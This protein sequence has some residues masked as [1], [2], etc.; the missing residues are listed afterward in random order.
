[1]NTRIKSIFVVLLTLCLAFQTGVV[2]I[3]AENSPETMSV[4]TQFGVSDETESNLIAEYE[5][6]A[7]NRKYTLFYDKK[8]AWFALKENENGY[9][10]YSVPN[11]FLSD[12]ITKLQNKM[13]V[14]SQLIVDYIYNP[15]ESSTS[16]SK[17]VNSHV[18][19]LLN[20]RI[21]TETV[22]GGFKAVYYFD[23]YGFE[24]PVEYR[25]EEDCFAVTVAVPEIKETKDYRITAINVLPM[26]G[27]GNSTDNGYVLV[28]DGCGAL[29]E[30]NN[31]KK[32]SL[33]YDKMLYGKEV[34][35]TPETQMSRYESVYLPVIS[36]VKNGSNALTGIITEGDSNASIALI[37]GNSECAYTS[38]SS[39]VNL[40]NI[41]K[42]I[43]FAQ[44]NSRKEI[45]STDDISDFKSDYRI[46][47]YTHSG[48][49]ANYTG[50]AEIYRNYL[51]KEKGLKKKTSNPGAHLN[52]Y[53]TVTV[54]S[55]F[56]GIPYTKT[57]ALTPF[58]QAQEIAKDFGEYLS[59]VR[60]LG[61][62]GDI[63]NN[64]VPNKL[65]ISGKMGGNSGFKK[66]TEY[67]AKN[68]VEFYLDVDFTTFRKNS[69]KYSIKTVFNE[70]PKQKEYLRSVYSSKL[71]CDPYYLLSPNKLKQ[72]SDKFLNSAKK[73]KITGICLSG[74]T[75][76]LYGDY[77]KD[78]R[79]YRNQAEDKI[80]AVIENYS[81]DVSV[82][83][84]TA[85]A[86]AAPY[87]N[88][89]YQAPIYSSGYELFDKEIP[90]YQIVFHGYIPMT[91]PEIYQTQEPEV[92]MLNS[93]EGGTEPLY[94]A[95]YKDADVLTNTEYDGLYSS[96]YSLWGGNAKE[97]M[98]NYLPL[99]KRI[100]DSEI[101]A[102]SEIG[103]N[104]DLTVYDNG[105]EVAVNYSDSDYLYKD[106]VIKA[107]GYAVIERG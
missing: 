81:S 48:D 45:Y 11:D 59:S 100:A 50:A 80:S 24:I 2:L 43:L 20:G 94:A 36:T 37:N 74:I 87:M 51:V 33:K 3:K 65:K 5:T 4:P 66:F 58:D 71:N 16:A 60:L 15:D 97:D 39:K 30:F 77:N 56:F 98:K 25:I 13:N 84:K 38:V 1:M 83:G 90:F 85:N 12:E 89:I 21:K 14:R 93:V 91:S 99:L 79:V 10:W 96:A 27:A 29:V 61:W 103:E 17:F 106:T 26:F 46:K 92:T 28:P 82:A 86:Y 78:S 47:Y 9:I 104:V 49:K 88:I 42:K 102:H 62:S 72:V 44:T 31:G 18:G 41:T 34:T 107:K 8:N 53:G 63:L 22:D 75:N 95:I 73:N 55:A 52:L 64:A 68:E 69:G 32:S 40:R 23:E 101:V 19:C 70:I 7:E 35:G 6:A 67:L 54:D 76:T 57:I 105:I